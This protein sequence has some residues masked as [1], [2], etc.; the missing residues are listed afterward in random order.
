MKCYINA[1][2]YITSQMKINYILNSINYWPNIFNIDNYWR[3][4][5]KNINKIIYLKEKK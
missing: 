1:Q 4:N 5:F 2:I 3:L